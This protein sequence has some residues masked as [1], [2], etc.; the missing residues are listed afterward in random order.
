MRILQPQDQ[1]LWYVQKTPIQ[2]LPHSLKTDIVVVGGGMA[3]LSA[4][5]SFRDKGYKVVLLE[6]NYCG[7][8]ASGKSSGFITPDSE[9]SLAYFLKKYGA[10]EAKKIWD[11]VGAGLEHIRSN[12]KKFSIICDYQ[13]QDTLVVANNTSTFKSDIEKEHQARTSL[14]FDSTLYTQKLVPNILGSDKYYGGIRYGA[15]FGINAYLYCQAMKKVLLDNNV[16]VYED[17]PVTELRPRSVVTPFGTVQ[18]DYI[19]VC[20]DRFVPDLGKLTRQVYHAQTFLM[21]SQIL[22]DTEIRAIFPETNL[23]VW[24]TDFIYHYYRIGPENRLMLG[25]ASL[26]TMY[27][28]QAKHN[29]MSAAKNLV[30]YFRTKFPHS[31][32]EFRYIWP[33]LIGISKNLMPIADFDAQHKHIYYVTAA[34]GLPWAAALGNYSCERIVNNKNDFDSYF[35]ASRSTVLDNVTHTLLGKRL[36][37]AIANLITLS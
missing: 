25:G 35:S 21:I 11:F 31:K 17:T 34:A 18:A 15:T 36:S 9:L 5:Q 37:F 22:T 14:G 23:M 24:D 8:G 19:V 13:E 12:I 10:E 33:G 32:T 29:N 28:K 3:G 6:Q 30:T 16:A 1:T 26:Y 20:T 2:R 27:N 7:S 4:A